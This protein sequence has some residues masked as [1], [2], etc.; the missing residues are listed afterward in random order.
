MEWGSPAIDSSRCS[1]CGACAAICSTETL[2]MEDGKPAV[3]AA[4]DFGCIACGHCMAVC[5]T[6]AVSAT[7][8]GLAPG[9]AFPLPPLSA[10]AGAGALE[11][12]LQARR[13]TR[14]YEDRPVEKD[15]IERLLAMASTAP[16]GFPPS[17]VGVVVINGKEKV[18]ELAGD[19]CAAFRK[20][21]FLGTPIGSLVLRLMMSRTETAL[22]KRFVLPIV[23]EI[24][25]ARE[26]GRDLLFYDAPCV[27]IFHYPM[28]E[29][30]DPVIA[31]S[32]AS[33][34]AE[35][36]GLGSCIIGTLPPA[37]RG[38]A[39]LKR[40]WG[41]PKDNF[42]SIAMILGHPAVKF[43]NGVRRRFA[44]VEYL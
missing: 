38:S 18:R 35:A 29:T 25:K 37:M 12:L 3:K 32:Y 43:R 17:P 10:R 9:D 42:A 33:I 31:C 23:E 11:G 40:K 2:K 41:L 39:A 15:L 28:K 36:L 6:G 14:R 5:P 24:I 44:S 20:W 7:G 21:R 16:M 13:S 27:L 22:M 30:T 1:V 4:G 8:R 34:A 26:N 19:L